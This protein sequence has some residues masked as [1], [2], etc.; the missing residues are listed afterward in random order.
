MNVKINKG[1]NTYEVP[2]LV[3]ITGL[4]VIGGIADTIRKTFAKTK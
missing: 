3:C 2:A 4:L 1:E